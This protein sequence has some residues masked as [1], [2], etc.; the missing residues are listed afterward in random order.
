M[1][2]RPRPED[3]QRWVNKAGFT[4]TERPIVELPPYHYGF[5]ARKPVTSETTT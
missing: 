2:I 3:C 1:A 5:V 4:G